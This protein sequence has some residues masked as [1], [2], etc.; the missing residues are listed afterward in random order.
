MDFRSPL[1]KAVSNFFDRKG[2]TA[3]YEAQTIG[4]KLDCRYT[5]D[6]VL[7]NGVIIETKG[8]L[9]PEDRRK[10]KAVKLQ[11]PDLDLRMIFQHNGFLT[12]KKKTTYGKWCD[13]LGIPWCVWP[14]IPEDWFNV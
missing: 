9:S 6:F 8:F 14:N 5:P 4:Y 2:L 11:H 13:K 7:Q 3:L 1:E 10:M 12:K